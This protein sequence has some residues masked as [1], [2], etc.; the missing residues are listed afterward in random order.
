MHAC[1]RCGTPRAYQDVFFRGVGSQGDPEGHAG[2]IANPCGCCKRNSVHTMQHPPAV[3]W[4]N[5]GPAEQPQG[6]VL[7]REGRCL[8]P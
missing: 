5:C 7:G 2:R 4:R 8:H 3:A 1:H 6:E